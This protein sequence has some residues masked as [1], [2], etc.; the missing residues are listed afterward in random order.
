M[1]G[2][3]LYSGRCRECE[4]RLAAVAG[5]PRSFSLSASFYR[6]KV[7]GIGRAR[8]RVGFESACQNTGVFER[9]A[10][11]NTGGFVIGHFVV[12]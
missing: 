6:Q 12:F 1:L 7:C 3:A 10:Y 4:S 5:A 11:R 8:I 2:N 9:L